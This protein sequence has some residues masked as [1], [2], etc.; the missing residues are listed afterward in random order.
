MQR[1]YSIQYLRAVAALSVVALHASNRVEAHLPDGVIHALHLGHAGV[2]LFFVISGF[3]MWYIGRET[4]QSPGDFFLRR[5]VRVAP[6]YWLASLSWAAFAIAAGYAWMKVEAVF[7]LQSLLFIP[8]YSATFSEQVWPVLVPGWTLNY[9][10]FFYFLFG[11]S[12]ALPKALRLVGMGGALGILVAAGL[13]LSPESAI[14]KTYTSPL[15]LEFGAGC[16]VAELWR[17]F[18]GGIVRNAVVLVAG[19]LAFVLLAPHVD[20]ADTWGRVLGFGLPAALILMGTIGISPII[21]HWPLLERLG[22][23]SFAI[24]VFHVLILSVVMQV[25]NMVPGL[26]NTATAATLIVG[27]LVLISVIGLWLFRA[28][29]R[30]LHRVL[31]GGIAILSKGGTYAKR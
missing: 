3:I 21:P 12:L 17:R 31:M 1:L 26:H 2:D 8:H 29:E 7:L 22:D 16:V 25:W 11:L 20:E 30:P 28:V 18:P 24:Y 6:L 27:F 13:L 23:A 5:F 9:E 4:T 15:L 10:M 19:V 14:G